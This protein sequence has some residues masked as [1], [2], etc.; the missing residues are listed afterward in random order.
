MRQEWIIKELPKGSLSSVVDVHFV[1]ASSKD[2]TVYL[3]SIRSDTKEVFIQI[4]PG[5]R[6][7]GDRDK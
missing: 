4:A 3:V 1:P 7:R 2:R 6:E 5:W